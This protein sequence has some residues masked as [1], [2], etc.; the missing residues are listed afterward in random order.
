MHKKLKINIKYRY[1][2]FGIEMPKYAPADKTSFLRF[3]ERTKCFICLYR[4]QIY[5][6]VKNKTKF[7]LYIPI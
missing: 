7:I 5:I 3:T 4:V 1:T 2:Y 6:P